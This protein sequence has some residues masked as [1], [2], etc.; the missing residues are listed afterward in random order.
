MAIKVLKA[1]HLNETMQRE[2]AQEV[3]IM[4]F[5]VSHCLV[6]NYLDKEMQKHYPFFRGKKKEEKKKR[7]E[8]KHYRFSV[9]YIFAP[10]LKY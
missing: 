10:P 9:D 6:E 5:A 3:Y 2:F 8:K 4:R 1:G 7:K